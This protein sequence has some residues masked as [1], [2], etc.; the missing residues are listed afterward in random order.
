MVSCKV[1]DFNSNCSQVLFESYRT[2]IVHSHESTGSPLYWK[3]SAVPRM[4]RKKTWHPLYNINI[5]KLAWQH[6][7][8]ALE[9]WLHALLLVASHLF[10]SILLKIFYSVWMYISP[11][12]L[13]LELPNAIKSDRLLPGQAESSIF[14]S[15]WYQLV[16]LKFIMNSSI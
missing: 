7:S 11:F 8:R 15:D 12:C 3:R 13:C 9:M 16:A 14:C 5:L 4:D 10:C 2:K 6:S 1:L